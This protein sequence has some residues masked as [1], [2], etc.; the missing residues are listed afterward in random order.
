[1]VRAYLIFKPQSGKIYGTTSQTVRRP[2][3]RMSTAYRDVTTLV[4]IQREPDSLFFLSISILVQ[5]FVSRRY[6]IPKSQF[7]ARV[8]RLFDR[9][10]TMTRARE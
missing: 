3:M 6:E 8:E 5:S 10:E 1:M 2:V 4:H 9:I 7:N